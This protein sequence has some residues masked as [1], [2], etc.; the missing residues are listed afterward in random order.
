MRKNS[1]VSF[2]EGCKALSVLIEKSLSGFLSVY[3][4]GLVDLTIRELWVAELQIF[5]R[6]GWVVLCA[7]GVF[8]AL[9]VL[10]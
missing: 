6:S 10:F 1:T 4:S 7:H 9:N 5:A 2:A 3:A 8:H